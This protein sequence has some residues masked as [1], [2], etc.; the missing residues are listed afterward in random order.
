M[1]TYNRWVFTQYDPTNG[2]ELWITDGTGAGTLLPGPRI[3]PNSA[4]LGPHRGVGWIGP[5]GAV[6]GAPEVGGFVGEPLPIRPRS[7]YQRTGF[8][9]HHGG[10]DPSAP[11]VVEILGVVR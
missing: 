4:G 1:T 11:G 9:V 5:P 7:W 8:F 6:V 2:W 3:A 10:S